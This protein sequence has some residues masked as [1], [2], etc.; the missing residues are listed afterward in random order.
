MAERTERC[1]GC[2]RQIF[3]APPHAKTIHCQVC[4]RVTRVRSP[5]GPVRHAKNWFA[6]LISRYSKTVSV[7]YPPPPLPITT[8]YNSPSSTAIS[9][10]RPSTFPSVHGRRRALLIG[11]AYKGKRYELNGTVNDV[12]CMRYFLLKSGFRNEFIVVLTEEERDPWLVPTRKNILSA[13]RWLVSDCQSGDSLVFHFSGHGSQQFDVTGDEID[14][15]DET[16]CPLDYETNGVIIDDEINEIMVRPL[17]KNVK[18][19][20]I[21]DAC[22][23]GTALDLPYLCRMN[24]RTG[25][26]QWED[27]RPSSGAEKGTRGGGLAISISGCD[28]N[29]TSADTSA[30]SGNTT[31]GAMTYAFIKAV[32]SDPRLTYGGLLLAMRNA[33]REANTGFNVNNGGA[34]SGFLKK[35]FQN[36]LTQEPQL[37][38]S[39]MFDVY[40]SSFSL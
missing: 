29:Q 8:Q 33:I 28:D 24:T 25:Y 6:G 37:C 11:I 1:S 20:G 3:I 36:G 13:M 15:F 30:L 27:H 34:I 4:G 38:S 16:L 12:K 18:L 23:S 26:F 19:H 2:G 39:E 17:T 32:E 31:T 22:H 7:L 14:G 40:R 21:V 9:N 10:L 5:A 35:M